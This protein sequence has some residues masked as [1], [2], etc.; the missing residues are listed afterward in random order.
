MKAA[1]PLPMSLR[2]N[3][4]SLMYQAMDSPLGIIVVVS[5]VA[6]AKQAFQQVRKESGDSAL[7][8]L[9]LISS[10][11][12]PETELW[13]VKNVQPQD[14]GRSPLEEELDTSLPI[15]IAQP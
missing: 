1:V 7:R 5:D 11:F 3:L 4:L 10:P 9:S 6:E 15:D 14:V 13:L 12:A 2:E 8:A